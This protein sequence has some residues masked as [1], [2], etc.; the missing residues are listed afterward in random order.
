MSDPSVRV[1]LVTAP[2]AEVGASLARHLVEERLAACVN[3][4]P[5]VR[6][7][8]RWEGEIHESDECL[9]VAKTAAATTPRLTERV[10]ELHP[11]E[12]PEV[13]ALAV[14]RGLPEYLEW[15]DRESEGGAS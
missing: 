3:V 1:V 9:L 14:E 11:Y 4:L 5:G 6:S 7:V 15:V 2:D 10:V 8:Y 12:V 13:L